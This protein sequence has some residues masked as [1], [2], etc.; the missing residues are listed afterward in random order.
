[1]VDSL[2]GT[3]AEQWTPSR[4]SLELLRG[5]KELGYATAILSNTGVDIRPRL[6]EMGMAPLIDEVVLSF[7]VGLVKPD[8][9]IFEHT[10]HLLGSTPSRCLMVGDSPLHDG[11]AVR[12]GIP[13]VLV[14]RSGDGPDLS[15]VGNL[16]LV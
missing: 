2:Y 16:L 11:G 12:A 10:V 14:P 7:E 15:R 6:L 5:L 1:L 3:M 8:R 9:R 13:T 4:N